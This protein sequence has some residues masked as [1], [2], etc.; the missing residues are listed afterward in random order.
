MGWG[1]FWRRARWER[2]R[3]EEIQSYLEIETEECVA[4]GMPLVEAR[5]AAHRKFGNRTLVREEIYAMNT[6]PLLETLARDLRY[7]FRF[8]RLNPLFTAVALLT[9][10]IGIGA[11][12]AVFTVFN[13]VL[14]KPLDY[15]HPEELVAVWHKAPG[16]EGLASASGDLRLSASMF[17]TYSEQ[18]HSFQAFGVWNPGRSTVTGVAE[19]EE[20]R[21]VRVS[22]GA[23]E[24]L[25]VP[26]LL[27][28]RLMPADQI[29]G[30]PATVVLSHGYWQRRFGGDRAVIGRSL[31]V[32]SRPREIVGVMPAGF[33]IVNAEADLILPIGFNRAKER[34]PGFGYQGVARLRPG[35]SLTAASADI[36]R[37]VPVWMNSWPMVPG[38]S[39]RVYDQW[40]ITPS[41]RPLRDDVVGN[42]GDVLRVLMATIGIVMLIAAANVANLLLVR[43]E[44]RQQELA[45]RTALGAGWG[46]IVRELLLESIL[47]GLMGG[48][49]GLGLAY[50]GI[51]ALVAIGPANLPRLDEIAI[52]GRV[53]AFTLV[54]S[55]LAAILIGLIPALKY[56]G[57]RLSLALRGGG[58]NASTSRER[59]RIRGLLVV[60]QMSMALV[61]LVSA[62]LMIRTLVAM[63]NVEPGFAHPE[64]LQTVRI[65]IP[66]SLVREPEKVIRMQNDIADKLAALPEVRSVAF[67]TEL[68]MESGSHDWDVVCPEGT[69]IAAGE[70]PSLRV[71]KEVSPGLFTTM[72]TSLIAGRDFS[73]TEVHARRAGVLVS[74]NLAREFWKTPTAAVGKRISS[75]IPGAPMHEVIGIVE[76]VHENGTQEPAPAIVYWPSYADNK[77]FPGQVD[78]ARTV[79][80]VMRTKQAGHEGF[81]NRAGQTIWS[82]NPSTP[83]AAIRTM[84]DIYDRSMARTSF[85]LVI[86]GIASVM[87]LLLGLVGIYGVIAYTVTQ[88]RREI[89][90]RLALG[91]APRALQGMFVRHG[92]L[93]ASV[94]VTIG[95]GAAAGTARL[96]STLLF[97]ISPLDPLTY[98]AVAAILVAAASLASYLPARRAAAVDPAEA[99]KVE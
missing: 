55:L 81:W 95:L 4:R 33:R 25:A 54:F 65:T 2:E 31:Q 73:W 72:G 87:A 74:E 19:P 53:L 32:D 51:R 57:P 16:A 76:D 36:A 64:Q 3:L 91:A 15:P 37:L 5:A 96:M 49:L 18:N 44:A 77:Y 11:N 89:G 78:I 41:L 7:G 71:F 39:P 60:T 23:F 20:A 86:L 52:D 43:V 94:G 92:L 63:R 88:R 47:L 83:L 90:I 22:D 34:L 45:I 27:G 40:R 68:P 84:R 14:L 28:R 17:F 8:L 26:P 67:T 24:A 56:A 29:P 97:G 12:T 6:I 93:L 9:L 50:L 46:R 21:T 13:S 48:A 38:V 10:A 70:L 1:R 59:H 82:V 42:V 79:T 58:R 66:G 69:V 61:L 85:A 99:L 98:A 80:F 30:A 35:V 75:C 62:G